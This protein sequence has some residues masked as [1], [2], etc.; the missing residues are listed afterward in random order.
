M[1]AKI[2]DYIAE[3]FEFY[4]RDDSESIYSDDLLK[5]I[6]KRFLLK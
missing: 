6:N 4:E 2:R 1:T 5:I 3:N